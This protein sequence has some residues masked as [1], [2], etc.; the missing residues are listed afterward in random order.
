MPSKELLIEV[1]NLDKV[2]HISIQNNIIYYWCDGLE[3]KHRNS[4]NIYELAHK[5]KEWALRQ[6][7]LIDTRNQGMTT[8]I[9][10]SKIVFVA[11]SE[12]GDDALKS[13]F[14]ACEWIFAQKGNNEK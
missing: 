1:L 7:Y 8:V 2:L 12:Q 14:K 4:I 6:G 3:I 11:T 5:C 13:D 9:Y 10:K